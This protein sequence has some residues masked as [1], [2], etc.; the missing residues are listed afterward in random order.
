MRLE[1]SIYSNRPGAGHQTQV[2]YCIWYFAEIGIS[3]FFHLFKLRYCTGFVCW[4]CDSAVVIY[5]IDGGTQC[6]VIPTI[7][8]SLMC[9]AYNGSYRVTWRS[10]FVNGVSAGEN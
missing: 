4:K 5:S 9:V 10:V 7:L 8:L 6:S 1:S 3:S 2:G